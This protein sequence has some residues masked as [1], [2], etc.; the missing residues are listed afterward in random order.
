M[1]IPWVPLVVA[2]TLVTVVVFLFNSMHSGPTAYGQPRIEKVAD[3]DGAETEVSVAPDG[4]R[5]IAVASGDLW[6]FDIAS[7]SRQRLTQTA[8]KE[9][10]PAWAPDGKRLTFTRGS[11]T[12]ALSAAPAA[13]PPEPELFKENATSLSWSGTGRLAFVRDRTLWVT[14]TGGTHER[15]FLEPDANPE[16]SVRG[17]R[18]SPNSDQIAFIKTNLGLRGEIWTIDA[19]NGKARALV[20][21]RS[22]ENPLDVG[23]IEDGRKLVYLTNRSGGYGLWVVDLEANTIAPLTGMLNGI[24][25]ERVGISARQDRIFLPRFDL[26]SNIVASDG[27]VVAQTGDVEFEPAASPDGTLVAYT[28]QKE[29][30]FEIWTAG[31]QGEI[32]TFRVLGTQPRFSANGFELV[33]THTDILGQVDLRKVDIRDGSSSSVTDAFEVDF[34]PDW[35]PDGRTIAFASNQGGPMTLWTMPTVGGKRRSLNVSGYFPRFSPDGRSLSYWSQQALWAVDL[36]GGTPRRVREDLPEPTPSAWIKG[37]PKTFRD[38]EVNGG[39]TIWPAVDILPD[40][41]VLTAPIEIRESALWVV[42]LTYV[43]K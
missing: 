7:G 42:N 17:P 41:R 21:D 9:S 4:A 13:S 22:A 28:I 20:A 15:A 12:F 27:T 25:P 31:S 40:G 39:K 30:K 33:Y 3:L 6:L 43:E 23:W 34:E 11:N 37:L 16:I 36:Q 24:L 19:S 38:P 2:A 29:N 10:F 18:F 8:D 5:L 35:S 1:K 26:D 32:P 14:D